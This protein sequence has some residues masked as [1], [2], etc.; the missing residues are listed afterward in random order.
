MGEAWG[1][2]RHRE[3][4]L[5][6]ISAQKVF[7]GE[8]PT[9]ASPEPA[10]EGGANTGPEEVAENCK[11]AGTGAVLEGGYASGIT[12][13]GFVQAEESTVGLGTAAEGDM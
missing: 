11:S 13:D 3:A 10:E 6:T 12:V 5:G 9:C 1:P 4:F 8:V 2:N 7:F